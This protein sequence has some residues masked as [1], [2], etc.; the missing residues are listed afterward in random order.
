[1]VG[2]IPILLYFLSHVFY[3]VLE[4]YVEGSVYL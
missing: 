4:Y 2:L 3:C 1:M